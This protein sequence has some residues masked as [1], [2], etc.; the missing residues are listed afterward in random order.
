MH[1]FRLK[2]REGSH[3]EGQEQ[4]NFIYDART[5]IRATFRLY[6]KE[7]GTQDPSKCSEKEHS[8]S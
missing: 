1:L 6:S 3:Y 8:V 5:R 2:R 4:A 7:G